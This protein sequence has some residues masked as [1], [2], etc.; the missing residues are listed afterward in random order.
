MTMTR[1]APPSPNGVTSPSA[2]GQQSLSDFAQALERAGMLKR[3]SEPTRVDQ[4][5]PLL[6]ANPRQAV[7]V[8]QVVDSEFQF[9]A[10][11]YSNQDQYAWALGCTKAETGRRLSQLAQG[12]V[13]WE[14]VDS[15]PCKDVVLKGDDV[16]LTRLPQF[17]YHERDGHAYTT[18]N[19]VISKDPDTGIYDWGIYRSMFRTCT[20]KNFDMTCTS[21]RQ[22]LH[23]LAARAKG[24]NLPVAVV[25]GVPLLDHLA[26]LQGV[27]DTTDDFEV[28]G[29]F[30]GHAAQMVKCETVDLVVPA[31]AEIVLEGE[32]MT[33]EGWVHDEG[34]F[35]EFTGMYGGGLKHNVRFVVH[36]MTYRKGGIYQY[37]TVG[38]QHP[39]YTDN[40][41]QLPMIEADLF[42]GLQDAGIDV[43]EV[44]ADAPGLSNIA[45]AKIRPRGGGDAKQALAV[46]LTCSKQGLPKIAMVFD[47]DIDIWDDDQVKWAMAFRFMPDRDTL[48]IPQ[49]NT[50]SVDPKIA[51]V[52]HPFSASKIGWDCTI[53]LVGNW[54]PHNFDRCLEADLG[55]PPA[56]VTPMTEAQLSAD[57]EAFIKAAPRAWKD[58]LERYL[59]QPYPTIYRAFGSLR[60]RLGRADN[61]PWYGYTFSDHEFAF[62]A[63]PSPALSNHDPRHPKA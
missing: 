7:L 52:D 47:E 50:M 45:Y 23:G 31:N 37:A 57:M 5:A 54:D 18:D 8:E 6:R 60:H 46:M 16:D 42:R 4:L 12:R 41:I 11:A 53:P 28:L 13:K 56:T 1:T 19:F 34:P 40:M 14:V 25:I 30:Y 36:C 27:P 63:K 48:I 35:G 49:C 15:A 39:G 58:I 29:S 61:A 33:S 21:H 38:G 26:G 44:R 22:R 43:V 3:I 2:R 17:L 9:L 32:L 59:G 20:E 10:N 55:A 62:G 24:Q 51:D